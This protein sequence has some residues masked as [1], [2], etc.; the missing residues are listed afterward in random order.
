MHL[1][2]LA[3]C[4]MVLAA[5]L[6]LAACADPAPLYVDQAYIRLNPNADGP[7]AGYFTVHGGAQ[8]AKL[9]D[10]TAEGAQR[11]EMHESVEKDGMMTMQTIDS[12]DVPAKGEVKFAPGGKH[13]MIFNINP[14]IVEKGKM[15]MTMIFSTGDRLIVDA[16]I[17]QGGDATGGETA[18]GN[19]SGM[20]EHTAH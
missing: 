20:N 16:P 8:A 7:A 10:V 6:A 2:R 4:L 3:S 14:A 15:T 11:I 18:M 1:P 17:Q 5:P 19:M 9:L 12:V 13:L